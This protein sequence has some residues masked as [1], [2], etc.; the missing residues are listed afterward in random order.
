M[1][2]DPPITG[3]RLI[4]GLRLC[5]VCFYLAFSF[6]VSAQQ[7]HFKPGEFETAR[8]IYL[9]ADRLEKAGRFREAVADHEKA[10]KLVAAEAGL[11][12]PAAIEAQ[13]AHAYA[14]GLSGEDKRALPIQR[15]A[16]ARATRVLGADHGTTLRLSNILAAV[17]IRLNRLSEALLLAGDSYRRSLASRG[18]GDFVTFQA[19]HNLGEIYRKLGRP[20]ESTP[21]LENGYETARRNLGPAHDMTLAL[22]SGLG[23]SLL[24][25]QRFKEAIEAFELNVS[26]NKQKWGERH[27]ATIIAYSNLGVAY[28]DAGRLEDEIRIKEKT[29]H[30]AREVLGERHQ[31][32]ISNLHNLAALYARLKRRHQAEPLLAKASAL[33]DEVSG[34]LALS[35]MNALGNRANNL[36]EMGHASEARQLYVKFIDRAERLRATPGLSDQNRRSLF[37]SNIGRYREFVHLLIRRGEFDEALRV[38]ERIKARTL[39]E[40]VATREAGVA[41]ITDDAD[42]TAWDDMEYTA[43]ALEGRIAAAQPGRDRVLLEDER[44]RLHQKQ[45]ALRTAMATQYPDFATLTEPR[46]LEPEEARTLVPADAA[47]VSFV[48]NRDRL[49]V[50]VVTQEG[51]AARE[52][53][54]WPQLAGSLLV[55]WAATANLR[56][57][58]GLEREL[59]R[60]VWELPGGALVLAAEA[61]QPQ[62][63]RIQSDSELADLVAARLVRPWYDLVKDRKRLLLSPDDALSILSFDGLRLNGRYLVEDHDIQYVP[64][65]A[66]LRLLREREA[67][68]AALPERKGVFAMGGARFQRTRTLVSPYIV[69]ETRDP[70]APAKPPAGPIAP[71][72]P[73]AVEKFFAQRNMEWVNLPGADKEAREIAG[74]FGAGDG[75]AFTGEDATETKL[76]EWNRTGELGRFRYLMFF[77]HG[78]LN[79]QEPSL[80]AIV[81]GQM[82]K[83]PGADGYITAA[84]F[85]RYRLQSDLVVLSACN[86]GVGRFVHGEGVLG[87]PYALIQAG[88]R[89]TVLTLWS[90]ENESSQRFT[91]SLFE[92]LRAGMPQHAAVAQ[93]KRELLASSRYRHPAYWAAYA[94]YGN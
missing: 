81:L 9:N 68:Y 32:T 36:M 20:T 73:H 10:W 53:P 28:G 87:L 23:M 39:A 48:L 72:D 22:L 2:S 38:A 37:A 90:V 65:F 92:K 56:G 26:L 34:E 4:F 16:L 3:C 91:K 27:H 78:Y 18:E 44:N 25:E 83:A 42:R 17:L 24:A 5:A 69:M 15:D 8:R 88:N 94:L 54:D 64:S 70:A 14:L 11:D 66:L 31:A 55:Y 80:S 45:E 61:P 77:T 57:I 47:F 86:T 46:A 30:L 84:E 59:K 71:G 63:R 43:A 33:A 79:L 62:A 12:H 67:R 50:L 89:N 19:I 76:E 93:A 74:L 29:L 82:H 35:S 49:L 60:S 6:A 51:I 1:G 7:T 41:A 85:S 40:L 58:D 52:L 75:V 21:L 13:A